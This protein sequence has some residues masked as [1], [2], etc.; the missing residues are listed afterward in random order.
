MYFL[1]IHNPTSQQRRG[2]LASRKMTGSVHAATINIDNGFIFFSQFFSGGRLADLLVLSVLSIFTLT[3]LLTPIG[4]RQGI[5]TSPCPFWVE[6]CQLNF[7][8]KFPN[9]FE[10]EN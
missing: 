4:M 8:Q 10:G 2:F 7:Y 5:F 3:Y 9:F 6:F 1:P